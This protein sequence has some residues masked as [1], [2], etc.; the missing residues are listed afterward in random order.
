[1][2]PPI[3]QALEGSA[4]D[5]LAERG[6]DRR[7]H[8]RVRAEPWLLHETFVER[9]QPVEGDA[10]VAVMLDV[11]ANVA[12]EN[13]KAAEKPWSRRPRHLVGRS[14][15]GDSTV[16]ADESNILNDDV[17]GAVRDKP[18]EQ[19]ALPRVRDRDRTPRGCSDVAGVASAR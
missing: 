6:E 5:A 1:M 8:I 10:R 12:R 7:L 11:V 9:R 19:K 15:R 17:P 3:V 14:R 18:V 4:A 13:E 16:L 2:G